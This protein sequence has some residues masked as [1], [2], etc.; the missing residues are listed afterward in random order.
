MG[1]RFF[2]NN[3]V[4]ALARS[5]SSR[6]RSHLEG[7]IK[8]RIR[9]FDAI[10]ERGYKADLNRVLARLE[11]LAQINPVMRLIDA[12]NRFAVHSDLRDHVV[13]VREL[14]EGPVAARPAFVELHGRRVS[15]N[16]GKFGKA[17]DSSRHQRGR[18][19]GQLV[20]VVQLDRA[21]RD[22]GL[23]GNRR[24]PATAFLECC[25]PNAQT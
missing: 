23:F 2:C 14:Q 5:Q 25:R 6:R 10:I 3:G 4:G 9:D 7:A 15:C 16:A 24:P 18:G 13:A 22:A 8:E 1:F 17:L 19:C 21:D 20:P 11:R 12:A